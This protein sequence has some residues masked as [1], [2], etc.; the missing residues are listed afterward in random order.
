[1]DFKFDETNLLHSRLPNPSHYKSLIASFYGI[2]QCDANVPR[3]APP[4]ESREDL[5][6][7]QSLSDE[8]D[9]TKN[10]DQLLDTTAELDVCDDLSIG[11]KSI[12]SFVSGQGDSKNFMASIRE[13]LSTPEHD[14]SSSS[15]VI[16]NNDRRSKS[17]AEENMNEEL[18]CPIPTVRVY[19]NSSNSSG[20]LQGKKAKASSSRRATNMALLYAATM[21]GKYHKSTADKLIKLGEAHFQQD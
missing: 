10:D 3:D 18:L 11:S 4:D 1:M 9:D 20:T 21:K 19:S 14:G 2:M 15:S 16:G 6:T 17:E 8:D 13:Y 12:G 5:D 7:S